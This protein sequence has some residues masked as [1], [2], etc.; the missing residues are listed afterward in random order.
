MLDRHR[1]V[2]YA[3]GAALLFAWVFL[4]LSLAG[5]D[6]ADPPGSA[7]DPPNAPP[8]NPCGPVGAVLAQVL[9]QT[10]G[11]GALGLLWALGVLALLIV[12]CRAVPE[13]G[14]RLLGIVMVLGVA[15]AG[16]GALD[17]WRQAPTLRPS[18]PVGSGGY[19]GALAA[20]FLWGQFGPVGMLLILVAVGLIGLALCHDLMIIWPVQEL[21]RACR[22]GQR[23]S[24]AAPIPTMTALG[25]LGLPPGSY[26]VIGRDEPPLTPPSPR[27]ALALPPVA[28][29]PR[30]PKAPH[31]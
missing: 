10:I 19:L 20:T 4:A 6:P 7:A 21:V 13:K 30:P 26:E 27:P 22:R 3:R 28:A 8:V 17:A 16:L 2:R 25:T 29:A 24:A 14:L 9:F 31:R 15:A 5:Y 18:P 11:W 12:R 1:L 23:R